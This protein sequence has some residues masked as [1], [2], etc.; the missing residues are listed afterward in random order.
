MTNTSI[1]WRRLDQPGHDA[2]LLTQHAN[3]VTLD[4]MAVFSESGLPCRL[5]YV[6]ECD[7]EWRTVSARVTGLLDTAVVDIAIAADSTRA[8]RFNGRPCPAVQGC[9]DVDLSFTPATNLLPIRRIR[10]AVGQ[11]KDVHAAWLRFPDLTLE[12]LDQVYER[13]S[14]ST[15]RYQSRQG[16]FV[17][18]LETNATRFVT[19]YPNLWQRETG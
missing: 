16:S 11:R 19:H 17:A 7:A 18:L 9:D 4:G 14:E 6:I 1:L 3:G 2:A 15:Y 12:L 5:H 10:L 13:V 8:W